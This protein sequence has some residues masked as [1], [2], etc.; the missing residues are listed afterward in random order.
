MDAPD[1]IK[2][3]EGKTLEFKRDASSPGNILR[4]IVAFANTA[5]G[6]L[7]VGV[8]DKTRYVR[9]V[10]DPLLQEERL[11]NLISDTI[12]PRIIPDIEVL[13]WRKTHILA[14]HVHPSPYRP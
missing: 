13:P 14:I 2:R 10:P 7:L 5:G 12:L 11:A 4:T 9:G 1:L 3:A 8:E 6:I